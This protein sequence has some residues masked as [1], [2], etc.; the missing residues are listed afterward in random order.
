[1]VNPVTPVKLGRV[2]LKVFEL[3]QQ[4]KVVRVDGRVGRVPL[5]V[6]EVP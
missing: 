2:P 5:K 1:V 3:P 6:F 4:L